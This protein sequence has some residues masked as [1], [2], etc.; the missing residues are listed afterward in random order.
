MPEGTI[1]RIGF[2]MIFGGMILLQ[3]AFAV[4]AALQRESRIP[5]RRLLPREGWAVTIL[6][7]IR[8]VFLSSSLVLY[9]VNPAWLSLL[10]VSLSAW[11]R[12]TGVVLGMVSLGLYAWSRMML[13][14]EWSSCLRMQQAH[15]LVTSGPYARIRHPIY[16]AM[17]TFMTSITLIAANGL[18]IALLLF[19]IVDLALRI[20]KE[21]RMMIEVLGDEY[22]DYMGRTGR[23][24]PK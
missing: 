5:P 12:W 6:R 1:F 22:R 11:M 15:Q 8:A 3:A 19:S 4:R 24:L 14:S 2:W 13:G 16:L 17:L 7:A 10:D 18:F 20:P 21:E 23:L 9:A